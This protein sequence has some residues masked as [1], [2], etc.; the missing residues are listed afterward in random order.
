MT[1][2]ATDPTMP[3][4]EEEAD[5]EQRLEANQDQRGGSTRYSVVPMLSESF[6]AAEILGEKFPDPG[7]SLWSVLFHAVMHKPLLIIPPAV[8]GAFVMYVM[9]LFP[10][11]AITEEEVPLPGALGLSRW[12]EWA[13]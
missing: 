1:N 4:A 10:H 6:D 5:G 7:P 3:K 2:D 13:A 9:G 8:C 12:A 11:C